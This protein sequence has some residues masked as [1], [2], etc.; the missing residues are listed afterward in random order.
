M[1]NRLQKADHFLQKSQGRL[2]VSIALLLAVGLA[3]TAVGAYAIIQTEF[4][5]SHPSVSPSPSASVTLNPTLTPSPTI[6]LAPTLSIEPSLSVTPS[7]SPMPSPTP[8]FRTASN[9][10]GYVAASNVNTPDLNVTSI[11]ASWTVPAVASSENDTF[12]A[13]WIGIGGQFDRTLIQCGTEQNSIG[14]N[15]IYSAWYEMLPGNARTINSIQVSAG[16]H[17]QASIQLTNE[18]FDQWTITLTDLTSGDQFQRPFTYDS[19]RSSADWIIERPNVNN[20]VSTLAD[21][22]NATF[23]NCQATIGGQSGSVGTF[24]NI[25]ILMYAEAP[26]ANHVQIADVSALNG[27]GTRFTVSYLAPN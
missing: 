21:F 8:A 6:T 5:P 20:K 15:L 4:S 2:T 13:V 3:L 1:G 10:A 7:S 23:T 24:P 9:W 11:S 16:D 12:S 17:I 22:G 25:K 19:S 26:D 27:D 14:G 18:A